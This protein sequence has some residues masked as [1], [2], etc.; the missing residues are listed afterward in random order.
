MCTALIKPSTDTNRSP[1]R[2]HFTAS[3]VDALEQFMYGWTTG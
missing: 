3:V 2:R 1:P